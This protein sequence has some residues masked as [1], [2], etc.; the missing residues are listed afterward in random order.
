MK[1][2]PG[3]IWPQT[4]RVVDRGSAA[5]LVILPVDFFLGT[6]PQ[7]FYYPPLF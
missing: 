3:V 4:W 6:G 1:R 5:H 7:S 2:G